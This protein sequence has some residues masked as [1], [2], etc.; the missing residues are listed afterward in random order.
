[1]GFIQKLFK[2]EG[3]P[4]TERPVPTDRKHAAA[5]P[6]CLEQYRS[7]IATTQQDLM[8]RAFHLFRRA[9]GHAA[10]DHFLEPVRIFVIRLIGINSQ[11]LCS[12]ARPGRPVFGM[13][14]GDLQPQSRCQMDRH[15]QGLIG[16]CLATDRSQ[17]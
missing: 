4:G 8:D 10:L 2:N 16:C 7:R 3:T 5:M 13:H 14:H 9:L 12:G 6:G 15:F 1:M 11:R 17:Y